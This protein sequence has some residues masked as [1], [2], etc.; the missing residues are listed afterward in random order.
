MVT[1]SA[2]AAEL[3]VVGKDTHTPGVETKENCFVFSKTPRLSDFFFLFFLS[4]MGRSAGDPTYAT[5]G[6]RLF[7]PEGK[8][9]PKTQKL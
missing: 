9:V 8:E 7:Q 4:L 2:N 3:L 1:H 6:C 5:L